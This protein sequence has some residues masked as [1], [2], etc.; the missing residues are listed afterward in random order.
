MGIFSHF[1]APPG[2][3]Q[4]WTEDKKVSIIRH[5]EESWVELF[6]DLAYVALFIAIGSAIE[7][8]HLDADLLSHAALIFLI[9]F[10]FRL[11]LDHYSNRYLNPDLLNQY[12]IIC[13]KV[14]IGRCTDKN[15]I[16]RLYLWHSLDDNEC[17]RIRRIQ[18][19]MS[20][21]GIGY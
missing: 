18:R 20:S 3:N 15:F 8:C 11:N 12:V 16:L 4:V 9:L 7:K 19:F 6:I 14:F 17:E 1:Y 21:Y 2:L 10:F 5:N 13:G